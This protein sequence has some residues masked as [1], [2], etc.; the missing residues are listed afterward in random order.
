MSGQGEGN[1][2]RASDFIKGHPGIY[3]GI[4]T[5]N[6]NESE[7]SSEGLVTQVADHLDI[8]KFYKGMQ[9]GG[10]ALRAKPSGDQSAH[11]CEMV[12]VKP[13]HTVLIDDQGVKNTGEAVRSRLKAIIVPDPIGLPR[14]GRRGVV[15]HKWVRRARVQEPRIYSSLQAQGLLARVAFNKL[16]K[17]DFNL[18][19]SLIDH[20]VA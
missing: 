19:G 15:E 8:L 20:R 10:V 7:G 17:I 16:A 14:E 4:I 6:T 5:N 11:F 2:S 9:I 1:M 12:R 18:I 13:E 3:F